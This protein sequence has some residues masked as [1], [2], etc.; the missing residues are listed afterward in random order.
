MPWPPSPP[1]LGTQLSAG[2]PPKGIKGK[3]HYKKISTTTTAAHI[4]RALRKWVLNVKCSVRIHAMEC[5]QAYQVWMMI[6]PVIQV[7]IPRLNKFK[8]PASSHMSGMW[9]D[10]HN[11]LL[12]YEWLVTS[13]K[14]LLPRVWKHAEHWF[15]CH[16][17]ICICEDHLHC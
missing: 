12:Y 9:P 4:Y 13:A 3:V 5:P 15:A 17:S 10:E 1:S 14:S 11:F 6:T 16:F 8:Q 7:N 2:H